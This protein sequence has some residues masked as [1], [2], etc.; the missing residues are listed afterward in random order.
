MTNHVLRDC[1]SFARAYIDDIVVFS[2]SCEEHL[3]HLHKILSCLQVA[4]LTIKMS[5]CQFGRAKVHYLG[6]VFGGGQVTPDPQKLNAV[7]DYLTPVS[8]KQVRAFLGLAGY[9]CRFV[10]HFSTIAEPLTELTKAEI[11]TK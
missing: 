3:T 6:H 5:K 2:S 10:S 7:R 4:N 8:K 11:L 9:Y 1:W